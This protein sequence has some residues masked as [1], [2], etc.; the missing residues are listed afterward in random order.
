MKKRLIVLCG[1]II[2]LSACGA[3]TPFRRGPVEGSPAEKP[4]GGVDPATETL[5]ATELN[6][7]YFDQKVLPML[8]VKC[9][10]CHENKVTD[11][12]KAKSLVVFN[13]LNSSH[14]YLLVTGN[15]SNHR[16]ILAP[17]SVEAGLLAYW[18]QGKKL[19]VVPT[20]GDDTRTGNGI[21][22]PRGP[23]GPEGPQGPPGPAGP[24]GTQG[25]PGTCNPAPIGPPSPIPPPT[26]I[27]LDPSYFTS[28]VIPILERKCSACH[29]NPAPDFAKA[30]T[31]VKPGKP[32]ES[33]LLLQASGKSTDHRSHPSIISESSTEYE[34][35][36][37]WILGAKNLE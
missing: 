30:Q 1:W 6:K 18:I 34:V 17:E 27:S 19:A 7:D 10:V 26:E 23:A 9:S 33:L 12:E 32:L 22:G 28:K 14:L 2:W 4:A 35:I 20:D 24:Q 11:F 37:N 15:L 16:R 31:L 21:P 3:P 29:D 13:D 5:S 8:E 36:K 25:P